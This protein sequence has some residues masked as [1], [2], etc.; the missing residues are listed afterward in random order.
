MATE[1]KRVDA[2]A[3]AAIAIL[4]DRRKAWAVITYDDLSKRVGLPRQ[5]LNKLLDYVALWCRAKGKRSLALL[6]ISS[7]TGRPSKGM[8]KALGGVKPVTPET[9]DRERL[10]LWRDDWSAVAPPSKK[11]IADARAASVD[12]INSN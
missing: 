9:F 12:Q 6:L 4:M 2:K 1:L 11:E 7:T 10:G 5:G 3:A 8:Y